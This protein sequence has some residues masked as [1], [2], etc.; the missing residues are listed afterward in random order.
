MKKSKNMSL[1]NKNT[2]TEEKSTKKPSVKKPAAKSEDKKPS[3]KELYGSDQAVKADDKKVGDEKVVSAKKSNESSAFRVL[4]KPLV[5]EK[6][7]ILGAENKYLFMVDKNANK[8]DIAKAV[9]A[10]Y[11]VKP[12]KVNVIN[13]E[14]KTKNRGKIVGKRKDWKK[15]IISLPEGKTIQI[16]E[17]I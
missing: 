15:A 11:G 1:F 5:T 2:K 13:I 6:G 10:A 8:I 4:I 3:M 7:S 12:V 9:E 16:Y 17:G 14:G